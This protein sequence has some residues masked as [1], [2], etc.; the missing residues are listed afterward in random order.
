MAKIFFFSQVAII[1]GVHIKMDT[2][3]GKVINVPIKDKT[4][5]CFKASSECIFYTNLN[6][7]TM[8]TDTNNVFLNAYSYL[9]TVKQNLQFF[10]D[11]NIEG[12]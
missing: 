5:I 11:S 2:S 10:T 3:K 1:V 6:D 12:A 7:P 4:I 8:I 9:S